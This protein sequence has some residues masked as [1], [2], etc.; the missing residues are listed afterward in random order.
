MS[1][2]FVIAHGRLQHGSAGR[3]WARAEARLRETFGSRVDIRFT[4]GAGEATG[5]ARCALE[6]GAD[7]LAAAGGDGTLNEVANGFFDA[8]RNVRP[9]AALSFIPAGSG[10][11]W[12]RTIGTPTESR[13]AIAAMVRSQPRR[14]D[15]GRVSFRC[16][17]GSTAER[18]FLNVAEAGAG[19][20]LV[21]RANES[22]PLARTRIGYRLGS[23]SVALTYERPS[24]RLVLDGESPFHTGPVLS[25]IIAGGRF[26]GAG[27]KCAPMALPDDGLLEVIVIGDFGKTELLRKIHTFYSGT[28]LSDPKIRHRSART[29]DVSSSAEVLLELDGELVGS[30]PAS[31]C[32]LPGALT[33]R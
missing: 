14:V 20:R 24:L 15:A 25:L 10:N 17:G 29:I 6:S 28:Y 31:F 4:A 33:I 19:G 1:D 18:V 16:G 11:D 13:A 26:F 22:G 30:L 2:L 5:L 3:R 7:W 8:G 32:V 9:S 21:A 27:M 23:I 12:A